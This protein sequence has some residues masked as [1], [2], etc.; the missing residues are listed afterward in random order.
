MRKIPSLFTR[1]WD[2]DRN[3][4]LPEVD[5]SCQWVIDGEGTATR[6]YDGTC[7]LFDA[8]CGGHWWAR[9]EVKPGKEPPALFSPVGEDPVTGKVMGWEPAMNS[10]WY[11][12]LVEAQHGEYFGWPEGT[13]ELCGPRINGNPEGFESHHLVRHAEAQVLD[14]APRD[15]EGLRAYLHGLPYEGIVWHHP[16]GRLAKIKKRD[17]RAVKS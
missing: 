2:G 17:F 6:K 9:R 7:V 4:V 8:Q 3:Y 12:F 14:D 13:Y 5:P 11:K 15:F 10:G 16:D 1:D